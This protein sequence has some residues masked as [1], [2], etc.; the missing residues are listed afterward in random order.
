MTFKVN[1][2][3]S[4]AASDQYGYDIYVTAVITPLLQS[5]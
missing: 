5:K 3:V 1:L 4:R 2:F